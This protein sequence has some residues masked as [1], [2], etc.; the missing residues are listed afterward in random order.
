MAWWL[1]DLKE[2]ITFKIT[3]LCLYIIKKIN[4]NKDRCLSQKLFEMAEDY[5]A[6]PGEYNYTI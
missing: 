6:R 2:S 4:P 5:N 3:I 1:D